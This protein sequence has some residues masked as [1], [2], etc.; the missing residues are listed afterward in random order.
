MIKLFSFLFGLLAYGLT[1]LIR[2]LPGMM[3]AAIVIGGVVN[4]PI[5]GVFT[6]GMLLP[7][8]DSTGVLVG[9]ILSMIT[10]VW[11]ATGGSVY[12][13]YNPYTSRTSPPYPGNI[14]GCPPSWVEY[15]EPAS[16]TDTSTLP[17]HLPIYD[18]SYIWYTTLG[19]SLV[20]ILA[21]FTSI[22]TSTDL[23]M[24]DKK[25]L[26]PALPGLWSWVPQSFRIYIDEWWYYVG[27]DL[28][29]DNMEMKKKEAEQI[30]E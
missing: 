24:L 14:T 16:P 10:T 29:K 7:W 9:F 25:L 15:Y 6:T 22:F 20:I 1:F 23:R 28:P 19:T 11:V 3:E 13:H 5:L 21:L 27:I 4:G 30:K 17:S 26:S 18:I 8:V 2:F 12:K